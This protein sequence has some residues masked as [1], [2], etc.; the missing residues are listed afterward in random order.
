MRHL[1]IRCYGDVMSSAAYQRQWRARHG[2]VTGALGRRVS[3]P[4]GTD[5]AYRRHLRAGEP[6]CAAC[7]AAHAKRMRQYRQPS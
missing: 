2:A 5:A 1:P 3:Q 6:A 7:L 4:C